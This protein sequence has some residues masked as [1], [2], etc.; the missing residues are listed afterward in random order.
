[1]LEFTLG[2]AITIALWRAVSVRHWPATTSATLL[3]YLL[4]ADV[5]AAGA[6]SKP[7]QVFDV[8]SYVFLG[9]LCAPERAA[10]VLPLPA[11]A[12]RY[13]LGIRA[14]R[15]ALSWFASWRCLR[16][17]S[18]LNPLLPRAYALDGIA[19]PLAGAAILDAIEATLLLWAFAM[20]AH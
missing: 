15:I 17:S 10:S 19:F 7:H 4:L 2:L 20:A 9:P 16:E 18:R 12:L 5:F 11:L 1:M 14:L 13:P 8:F 3:G 6:V